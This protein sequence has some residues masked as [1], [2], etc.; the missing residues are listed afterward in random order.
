[1]ESRQTEKKITS[2][3]YDRHVASQ[4]LQFQIGKY[5]KPKEISMK[6][7]TKI[8]LEAINPKPQERILD[9]GCGV[10]TFA[11]HT[12][13]KGAISFGIDYSYQSIEMAIKLVKKFNVAKSA[14]F[15][16]GNGFVLP[17]RDCSFDK[18]MALDFIE[19]ITFDEKDKFLREM[20][21]VLKPRGIGVIFTPNGVRE[22]IGKV[23]WRFRH[24]VF[25]NKIHTTDLHFGL[26]D[27]WQFEPLLRRHKFK[28]KLAYKDI[29]RPYLAKIPLIK[30]FL[31]LNLLWISKRT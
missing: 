28:F 13:K 26:T 7:R 22:K 4:G 3:T 16:V 18:V 25:G 5:Y 27:K 12:A 23:Y 15:L 14:R 6:R 8:V 20:Y 11:F 24:F 31:S 1:M 17:F 29:T 21:R 9:I 30:N 10:G 2:K 19:H